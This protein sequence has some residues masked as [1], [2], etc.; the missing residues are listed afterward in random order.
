MNTFPA[1]YPELNTNEL[2]EITVLLAVFYVRFRIL[3]LVFI[4]CL[5]QW[6]L[7]TSAS[8]FNLKMCHLIF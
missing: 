8:M 7:Q 5:P 4:F 3:P 2:Y 6:V 1:S